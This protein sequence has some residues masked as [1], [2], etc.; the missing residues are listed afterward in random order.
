MSKEYT[1]APF[2]YAA[3]TSV[4]ITWNSL[5]VGFP[6]SCATS[7]RLLNVISTESQALK[8]LS[9]QKSKMFRS[10]QIKMFFF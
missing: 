9:Y 10:L 8:S 1:G 7:D 3:P 2:L 6:L 5:H 4:V